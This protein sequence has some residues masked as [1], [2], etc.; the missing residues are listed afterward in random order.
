MLSIDALP[1]FSDNYI[2]LLQNPQTRHCAVVDPG[3]AGP[4]LAWLE[5]HANYRLS[6]ILL[7]HHHQDH[8]GGV[9]TL[10]ARHGPR[11]IGPARDNIAQLDLPV[12]EGD[13]LLVLGQEL[14]VIDTPG[15]TRG[16]VVYFGDLDG[17]PSLFC[18]DTL[19]AAGCGRLFEGS[20]AQMHA[21]LNKLAALPPR[22]LIYCAHEYTLANLR[23][24]A[25]AEPANRAIQERLR[26]V[27]RQRQD[28]LVS[29]PSTLSQELQTNPFLR[30][31]DGGLR[32]QLAAHQGV[33]PNDDLATFMALRAWK[34]RF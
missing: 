2:W 4:V 9:A 16:H 28:G 27:S 3:D 24:A 6:D 33:R 25:T 15:H 30:L 12:T 13:R 22:T 23:F 11:V 5:E 26:E 29:L 34:D 31:D 20:A 32:Q 14:R 8:T 1:A 19:F 10:K 17:R 18:G 7:T 21:S